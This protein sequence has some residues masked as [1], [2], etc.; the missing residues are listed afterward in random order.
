MENN[1]SNVL[2][3]FSCIGMLF[4]VPLV[5]LVST[6]VTGYVVS[7]LWGWFVIPLG[8]PPITMWHAYGVSLL[9]N[10]MCPYLDTADLA[11][12]DGI[13]SGELVGKALMLLVFRPALVLL[14][15]YLVHTYLM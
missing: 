15:G 10:F 6:I 13:T 14:F 12:K 1:K 8:L 9:F 5:L 4:L 3:A 7:Q 11:K 2:V